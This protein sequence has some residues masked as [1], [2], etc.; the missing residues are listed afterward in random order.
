MQEILQSIQDTN[1]IFQFAAIFIIAFIPF[2]EVFLAVPV[3]VVINLPFIPTVIVGVIANFISVMLV[4]VFSSAVKSKFSK[5]NANK[6][7][8]KAQMRFNKYGVPGISLLGPLLG[9][10]HIG[11]IVCILANADKK[12]IMLWQLIS[13]VL[14][15]VG[16][17]VVVLSGVNIIKDVM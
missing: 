2:L 12:K 1:I 10:N 15:A 8:Q 16:M 11:A 5:N 6:R 4:V 7:F 9:T 3:G 17:G 14:W 13:I